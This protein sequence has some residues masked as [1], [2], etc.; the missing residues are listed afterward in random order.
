MGLR[1]TRDII[2]SEQTEELFWSGQY[3][4]Q[5]MPFMTGL[6]VAVEILSISIHRQRILF[7]SGYLQEDT[8]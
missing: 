6:Q 5:K 1:C 7:A 4:D 3:L 2:D 8:T